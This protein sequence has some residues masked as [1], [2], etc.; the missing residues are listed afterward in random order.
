MSWR[1]INL[2]ADFVQLARKVDPYSQSLAHV[3]HHTK[4]IVDSIVEVIGNE[5]TSPLALEP[6][7]K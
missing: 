2:T 4:D 3:L 7:L 5:K 6:I 1:D